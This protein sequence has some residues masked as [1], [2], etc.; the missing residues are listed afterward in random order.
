L[1]SEEQIVGAEGSSKIS[2]AVVESLEMP[3]NSALED[4]KLENGTNLV[5]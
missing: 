3:P 1:N 2:E 4:Q 5:C